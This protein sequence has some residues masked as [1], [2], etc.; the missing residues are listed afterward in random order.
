MIYVRSA[1]P[2]DLPVSLA[3]V[4]QHLRREADD[5]GEDLVI[6]AY[7]QAAIAH[8]DGRDGELGRCLLTQAWSAYAD[9]P[10]VVSFSSPSHGALGFRLDLPPVRTTAPIGVSHRSAGQWIAI[11]PATWIVL[12][13]SDGRATL[14]L[15]PGR[16][17]PAADP[18]PS[19]WRIDFTAGYGDEPAD[20]PAPI[21]AAI[22]LLAADMYGERSTKVSANLVANP[23]L[24]RLLGPYRSVTV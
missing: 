19:A 7:L 22:L 6:D 12:P 2:A 10:D 11:D 18:V 20:V 9:R 4:K 24:D 17:W 15:G 3:E 8:L 23:T 1:A 16:S 21:R 5:T 14:S 13:A